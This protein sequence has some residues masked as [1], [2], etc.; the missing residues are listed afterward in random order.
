[1][2][3][4]ILLRVRV[5]AVER[6]ACFSCRV[7]PF[8]ACGKFYAQAPPTDAWGKVNLVVLVRV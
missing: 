8:L 7:D 5:S 1:M 3:G 4:C 2:K 6:R